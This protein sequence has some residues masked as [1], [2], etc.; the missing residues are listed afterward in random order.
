[1]TGSTRIGFPRWSDKRIDRMDM[2]TRVRIVRFFFRVYG[3]WYERA[4][5]GLSD[6]C[7]FWG[8]EKGYA[9]DPDGTVS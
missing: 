6:L 4:F 1:M 3:A 5:D 9:V 2:R 8:T 7:G